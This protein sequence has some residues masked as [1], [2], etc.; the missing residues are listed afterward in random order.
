MYYKKTDKIL[1]KLKTQIK[2]S[3]SRYK[4]IMKFDETN[5]LKRTKGLY[6]EL[7][8]LNEEAFLE[9]ANEIYKEIKEQNIG[10]LEWG[11]IEEA[12]NQAELKRRPQ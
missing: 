8:V 5:L 6:K 4:A 2:K 10:E 9:M 11:I 12:Y 3:F 7:S 1:A